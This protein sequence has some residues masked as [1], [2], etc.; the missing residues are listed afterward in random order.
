MGRNGVESV[1]HGWDTQNL[2]VPQPPLGL[3]CWAE[4]V[5]HGF[6]RLLEVDTGDVGGLLSLAIGGIAPFVDR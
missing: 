6:W 5:G 2:R 4:T 3:V 1:G